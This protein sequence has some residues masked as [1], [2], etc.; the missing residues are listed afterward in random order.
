MIPTP[1]NPTTLELL[2]LAKN[3]QAATMAIKVQT[4]QIQQQLMDLKAQQDGFQL[5][6]KGQVEQIKDQWSP[7]FQL[8]G[9]GIVIF[10]ADLAAA[11][12]AIGWFEKAAEDGKV[13][14][15]MLD[16]AFD[17]S[18]IAFSEVVNWASRM[19][20]LCGQQQTLLSIMG[21]AR[22]PT[23]LQLRTLELEFDGAASLLQ[24]WARVENKQNEIRNLFAV[25]TRNAKIQQSV[26]TQP[27]PILRQ[28]TAITICDELYIE[29]IKFQTFASRLRRVSKRDRKNLDQGK[30]TLNEKGK[31]VRAVRTKTI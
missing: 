14:R 21:L 29:A 12:L 23:A 4:S 27:T 31:V 6:V 17:K 25:K 24:S 22:K 20:G 5:L 11:R 28:T 10:I 15:Q 3:L 30:K 2:R 16:R 26:T 1:V 7:W 18:E 8:L 19:K 13:D 9:E